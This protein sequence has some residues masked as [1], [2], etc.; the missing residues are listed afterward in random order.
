MDTHVPASEA[1]PVRVLTGFDMARRPGGR[2]I[3]WVVVDQA[4][5]S[6]TNFVLTL[7]VARSVTG[8]AF[9]AFGIAFV[10]AMLAITVVRGA[11]AQPL[12]I[13]AR[14]GSSD[15]SA[16]RRD[17]SDA[18]G[19]TVVIGV[20]VAVTFVLA[21]WLMDGLVGRTVMALG[22]GLPALLLQDVWRFVFFVLGRPLKAVV[23]DTVMLVLLVAGT[24]AIDGSSV[25]MVVLLWAGAALVASGVAIW[26]SRIC[27]S[28]QRS[29][30][31]IRGHADLSGRLTV[32]SIVL[33]GGT[34]AA[35][36]LVGLAVGSAGVGAMRG[37][38]TLF[39]PVA[40][41]LSGLGAGAVP[42]GRRLAARGDGR[43]SPVLRTLSAVLAIGAV[44][45]GVVLL[46][47][48]ESVGEAI[49]GDT[50]RGA[51]TLVV[52][53]TAITAALAVATGGIIGL[54][55]HAAVRE[56]LRLRLVVGAVLI[57]LAPLAGTL[58][59]LTAA[60]W[61]LA[62]GAW[63]N[64]IGAWWLLRSRGVA[65]VYRNDRQSRSTT[66]LGRL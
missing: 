3:G 41:V 7:I 65:G 5:A 17:V 61:G 9:G 25:P 1:R 46:R 33:A 63:V 26:Q 30:A 64:A 27:P 15:G 49:L 52:P 37:A 38:Q 18:L 51:R 36:L 21:G 28:V 31:F 44:L 20:L 56:S 23:N 14:L 43:L 16:T 6:L 59:G 62:A 8:S 2:R 50:W 19:A 35:M 13:R 60:A 32:E 66:R 22:I 39:G 10:M 42:E 34:Y 11:V 57:S 53:F 48:P 4:V 24:R 12:T 55:I 29:S 58:W 45:Q 47:L 40:V 54:R